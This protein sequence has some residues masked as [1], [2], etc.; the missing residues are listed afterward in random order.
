MRASAEQL[1]LAF[2]GASM[3]FCVLG[4]GS[5]GNCVLVESGDES[6]LVDAGFSCREIERRLQAVGASPDRFAAVILTH[7]H[8]DHSRGAPRF[9]RRHGV[10]I[11]ATRGTLS[12]VRLLAHSPEPAVI[13]SGRSF[14]AGPFS[15]EPFAVPHDAR[16]PVGL[17]VESEGCRLGLAADLGRRSVEAWRRLR[18]LDALVL[19]TNHDIEML[20]QGPYPWPLKKRIAGDNGHLSNHD[21]A[22]GLREIMSRRLQWVVL[23]HLSRTNNLP[24]LAREAVARVLSLGIARTEI[25]VSEQSQPTPWLSVNA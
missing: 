9:S 15:I 24:V 13:E 2:G 3:R 19:E 16:E 6:I 23:Y 14:E 5:A 22:D 25:C 18:N 7:E 17:V 12:A 11:Y 10:P 21:A 20:Q 1:P 8:G 4:S